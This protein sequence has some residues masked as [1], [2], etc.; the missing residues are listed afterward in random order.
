MSSP[1][2]Q[3]HVN[4]FIASKDDDIFSENITTDSPYTMA[5]PVS[6]SPATTPV[7]SPGPRQR[8]GLAAS[9]KLLKR[10]TSWRAKSIEKLQAKQER[11][12]NRATKTLAIVLGNF[13]GKTDQLNDLINLRANQIASFFK[14]PSTNGSTLSSDILTILLYFANWLK[15]EQ[16]FR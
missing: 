10:A 14:H 7:H 4:F 12:E 9:A 8:L 13:Q 11:R 15:I 16:L 1:S 5:T 3:H 2:N 6:Q